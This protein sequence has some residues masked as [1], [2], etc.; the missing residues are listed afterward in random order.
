MLDIGRF[1]S[2]SAS[3]LEGLSYHEMIARLGLLSFN[4]QGNRPMDLIARYASL[5]ASSTVLVV[6]CGTGGTAVHLAETTGASVCGLDLASE[7]VRIARE[8]ATASPARQRLNFSVG[9][10][11]A[12][13]GEP[14][15]KEEIRAGRKGEG[16]PDQKSVDGPLPRSRAHDRT[17]TGMTIPGRIMSFP[18]PSQV[19][20]H[21][22]RVPL[23]PPVPRPRSRG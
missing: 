11:Q 1:V 12:D 6:G 4:S 19:C 14:C 16:H 22:H 20:P 21:V 8:H 5:T 18:Q 23:S 3:E 13:G 7:S 15:P 10:A 9:D 17:K 2:A